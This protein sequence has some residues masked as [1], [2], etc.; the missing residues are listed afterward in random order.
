MQVE[1]HQL[2]MKYERLK[3]RN[4][5]EEGRV[6]ALMGSVG[7][8]A[9]VV[10]VQGPDPV[11][12]YVLLDGFKRVR[13]A[14]RL[15]LDVVE[16]AVWPQREADALV[17]LHG[18]Q[19]PHPRNALEDGYLVEVLT[20]EHGLSLDEAAN[21]LGRSKSWASRRLGLV[22]ELPGWLQGCIRDGAMQ[23]YAATKYVVPLARA[24]KDHAERL[25]RQL[26]G[27]DVSTRDVGILYVAWKNGD[28]E[29]Q[30]MVVTRP[31]LVLAAHSARRGDD[32]PEAAVLDEL[33]RAEAL[34][35]RVRRGLDRLAL[36]GLEDWCRERLRRRW[37]RVAG[38]MCA[39]EKTLEEVLHETLGPGDTPINPATACEG[40]GDAADRPTGGM[41]AGSGGRGD[42]ERQ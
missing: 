22:K 31:D 28:A 30:E 19:R 5:R 32:G 35:H 40:C 3:V 7:Q 1:L 41:L 13:A 34:L 33:A 15:G 17:L 38:A 18:L 11:R 24:N 26:S 2:D 42:Q 8:Q 37:G 16:A 39:V 23:C 12:P 10:V 20:T 6:L 36:A 29:Q 14:N 27:M 4:R 21:R 9:A 25:A